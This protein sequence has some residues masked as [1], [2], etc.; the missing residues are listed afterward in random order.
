MQVPDRGVVEVDRRE[1]VAG[2]P[3]IYG[4]LV[5]MLAPFT[6]VTRGPV[7]QAAG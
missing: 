6:G 4:Q 1:V 5:Q 7:G 3:K 2:T